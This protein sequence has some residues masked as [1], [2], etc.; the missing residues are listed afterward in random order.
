MA[1][2]DKLSAIGDAIRE[3]TGTTELMTL[4]AMPAAIQGIE[5]GGGIEVEPIVLTGAQSY[6]CSGQMNTTYIKNFGNTVTTSGLLDTNYMFQNSTLETVP[7]ELNYYGTNDASLEYMFNKAQLKSLPKMNNLKPGKRTAFCQS[8]EYLRHIPQDFCDTWN[9]S[10]LDTATNAYL[11]PA[12]SMFDGCRSLRSYPNAIIA[13]GNPMSVPTYSVYKNLFYG[14]F[15]LDEVIDLP[16]AHTAT[17]NENLFQYT[18]FS[19]Y[20]LKNFTFGDIGPKNWSKQVLDLSSSVDWSSYSMYGNPIIEYNSGITAD[21][22]VKDDDTYQALKDDPDWFTLKVE[23]SRYNHDSAVATINS[24]PDT[25][26]YLATTGGTN[27]IKFTGAAGS[28][29]DGGAINTLTE[30]EIAVA[31]AKGWTVTLV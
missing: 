12:S 21:K 28:A 18:V 30:E 6:G 15:V 19:C 1:L 17:Y 10:A 14:C 20:R 9:W 11:Q 29:T 13:H 24:L 16:C 5:T 31:A 3:K 23:Y 25:S 7:F 8:A 4:D 2:I 26:A 27:T 22:E